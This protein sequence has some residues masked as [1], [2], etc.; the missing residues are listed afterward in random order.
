M[1]FLKIDNI[2]ITQHWA[3]PRNH[4]C[5]GNATMRSVCIFE[6]YIVGNDTN[7]QTDAQH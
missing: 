3:R 4:C 5:D 6:L 2:C 7:I 1:N